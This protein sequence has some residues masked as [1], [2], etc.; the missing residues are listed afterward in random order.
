VPGPY[1]PYRRP[2]DVGSESP[3]SLE[4]KRQGA[5]GARGGPQEAR[6]RPRTPKQPAQTSGRR[7]ARHQQPR[8]Q[9]KHF[10]R[11][12]NPSRQGR[13]EPNL[14]RVKQRSRL[15]GLGNHPPPRQTPPA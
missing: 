11:A 4:A 10:T 9:R 12:E 14:E 1:D 2:Q 3:A 8:A 7:A 5:A 6:T 13:G 15:R